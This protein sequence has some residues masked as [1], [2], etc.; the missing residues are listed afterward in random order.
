MSAPTRRERLRMATIS[1]IKALARRLLVTGGP[2]AISLRAIAREMGMTAPAIYRYFPSLD[3]LVTEL[4]GDLYNEL[5]ET[6]EQARERAGDDPVRQLAEMAR[7]FRRWSLAHPV[8]FAL[9]FGSPVPGAAAFQAAFLTACALPDHP[10]A[11]FGN[12]FVRALLE[13]W[14]QKPWPTPPPDLIHKQLGDALQPLRQHHGDMPIEVAYTFIS[15]WAR[16][17]GLVSLEVFDHLHWAVTDPERLFEVEIAALL[18]QL[19]PNQAAETDS[20]RVG[21]RAESD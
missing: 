5:R 6:V 13:L 11:R 10:G 14:R 17:Y 2:Q 4:T 1:E 18:A 9:V 19:S 16:L 15:G 3:A 12:P 8:E 21:R 20:G 7:G